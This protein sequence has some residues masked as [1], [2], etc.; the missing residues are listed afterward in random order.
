MKTVLCF[1]TELVDVY[2]AKLIKEEGVQNAPMS[3]HNAKI[4]NQMEVHV[5]NVLMDIT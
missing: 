4:A 5:T 1:S 3:F 2:Q